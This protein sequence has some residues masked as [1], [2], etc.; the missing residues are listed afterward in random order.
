MITLTNGEGVI[1]YVFEGCLRPIDLTILEGKRS[2]PAWNKSNQA[3]ILRQIFC[4]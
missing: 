2:A 3:L 1:D 4:L